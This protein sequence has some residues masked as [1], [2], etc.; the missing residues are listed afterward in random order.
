MTPRVTLP[1]DTPTWHVTDKWTLGAGLIVQSSQFLSGDEANLTPQ[2]AGFVT[3]NL[4]TRY[5]LTPRVQ[6][7]ALVDNMTDARY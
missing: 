4:S 2:L 1:S 3:L 7:F 6:F 5:Q